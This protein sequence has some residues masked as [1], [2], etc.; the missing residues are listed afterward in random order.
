MP[1]V[2]QNR[3]FTLDGSVQLASGSKY[4]TILMQSFKVNWDFEKG[5]FI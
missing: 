2:E 1:K 4:A 3:F 5:Q